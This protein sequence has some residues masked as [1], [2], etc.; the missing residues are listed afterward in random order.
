MIFLSGVVGAT[1]VNDTTDGTFGGSDIGTGKAGMV[2]NSTGGDL[3]IINFMKDATSDC[4]T[5]YI[6]WAN[7]TVRYTADNLSGNIFNFNPSTAII[8]QAT[9]FYASCDAGGSS[10]TARGGAYTYP[11]KKTNVYWIKGLVLGA[12]TTNGH[13]IVSI[14]TEEASP[15]V[16]L[17]Y[18]SNS[19]NFTNGTITFSGTISNTSVTIKNVSVLLNG[20]INQTNTSQLNGTYNFTINVPFGYYYWTYESYS[21][22]NRRSVAVDRFIDI[23]RANFITNTYNAFAPE[24]STQVFY[25]NFTMGSGLTL[26]SVNITYNQ[27][28]YTTTFEAINSTSYN[29]SATINLP[30]VASDTNKTFNWTIYFTDGSS[31]T[32]SNYQ[33]QIQDF[34]LDDCTSNTIMIFNFTMFDE[35]LSANMSSTGVN[36]TVKVDLSLYPN[37]SKTTATVTFSKLYNKI[38]PARVCISDALGNTIYYLD[39]Q[40]QYEADTYS[41]EYYN[42]QNY[43]LNSTSNPS[44]NITLYNLANNNSQNFTIT[45]KDSSFLPVTNALIQVQR[46]YVDEGISKVVEIPITSSQGQTTASLVTNNVIY[47]FTVTKNGKVLATFSNVYAVC[48]N[49][50]IQDCEIN[51]NSFSSSIPVTNFTAAK[52]FMYTL[53]YNNNT[54]VISSTFTIPSGA[55]SFVSLNVSKEDALGT[56]L[57]NSSVSSSAGTLTCTIGATLG[58][59]TVIAK[60]YKSGSLV[61]QGQV[62]IDAEPI[63]IYG[64][65]LV[66]LGLFVMMTLLGAGLSDNPVFTV[67]F[68]MLGVILLFALNLVAN[69]GFIGYTATI[70]W[71]VV[72]VIIVIVKGANRS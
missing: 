32:S 44:Q 66:V 2:F 61:G 38:N 42:L 72:A 53:T 37:A 21:T 4:T 41:R 20:T 39:G 67:I 10:W 1:Q 16:S 69:N 47:S 9:Q 59:G 6:L 11:T 23:R 35:D 65:V 56:S 7:Q 26:S 64:G 33:Q 45:Y 49:P 52:D 14:L 18:P 3:S 54:R 60:L 13:V 19:S 46:K 17:T 31:Q 30:V 48:Q 29:V 22:N 5:G 36:T 57:C 71:L 12:N 68:F 43:S 27:T 8:E 50:S 24:Q 70:L 34:G 62:K 28:N 25:T 58:N 15:S 63:D 55:V 40:I 51:L